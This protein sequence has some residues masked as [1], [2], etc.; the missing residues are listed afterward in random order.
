[1]IEE[2]GAEILCPAESKD[3]E[4]FDHKVV[5]WFGHK[6]AYLFDR[7]IVYWFDRKFELERALSLLRNPE[8]ICKLVLQLQLGPVHR[9]EFCVCEIAF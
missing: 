1:M 2:A 8:H 5:C 4:L 9:L 6:V 3:V 7:K